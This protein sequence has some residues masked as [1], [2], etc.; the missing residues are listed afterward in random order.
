MGRSDE[1][2]LFP[3]WFDGEQ[4]T[5]AWIDGVQIAAIHFNDE[6]LWP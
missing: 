4:M 6:R 3:V 2:S 1:G 5:G